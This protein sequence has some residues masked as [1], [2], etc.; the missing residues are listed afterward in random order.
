MP[1]D[2]P[3]YL[4]PEY[5][6][7]IRDA[8][9]RNLI[10]CPDCNEAKLTERARAKHQLEGDLEN[11]SFLTYGVTDA[12][13][14]AYKAAY[15]FANNPQGFLTLWGCYGTGK[16][17][18]LAAITNDLQGRGRYFTFPDLV[19]QLRNA[20]G[21]GMVE[22]FYSQIANIQVLIVD[23]IDK[24]SLKDWTQEQTLRLFDSRYRNH[25]KRGTVLAMNESPRLM[26]GSLG[27]LYS[28]INDDRFKCIEIGGGDNRP[29]RELMSELANEQKQPLAE[30]K[31]A[32]W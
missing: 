31:G 20:V 13:E 28:R 23:E 10:P 19:S 7:A 18:L 8:S 26:N 29:N 6:P 5:D 16:T 25:Q 24:A 9:Y 30:R 32:T 14:Q 17:H 4:R 11:K 3:G 12:N 2:I 1:A 15:D 21:S 22:E 27:Y